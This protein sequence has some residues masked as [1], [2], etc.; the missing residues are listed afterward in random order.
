MSATRIKV[1]DNCPRSP[2]KHNS[3]NSRHKEETILKSSA[4]TSYGAASQPN[5][6]G[7]KEK[8]DFPAQVPTP[9]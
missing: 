6:E 7:E 1:Q 3:E 8:G 9:F 5:H 2:G 4:A